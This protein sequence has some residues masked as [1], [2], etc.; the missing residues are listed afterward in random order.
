[1]SRL[2]EVLEKLSDEV[3]AISRWLV[4]RGR[5]MEAHFLDSL[6][7]SKISYSHSDILADYSPENLAS[8]RPLIDKSAGLLFR[9]FSGIC[10]EFEHQ[11]QGA[12]LALAQP[13]DIRIQYEDVTALYRTV[14]AVTSRYF[15]D[16]VAPGSC[17]LCLDQFCASRNP[18]EKIKPIL[19]NAI[20]L[21]PNITPPVNLWLGAASSFGV[22]DA[23]DLHGKTALC[24]AMNYGVR[25]VKKLIDALPPSTTR[26]MILHPSVSDKQ[27][28]IQTA[29]KGDHPG[30]VKLLLE[31]HERL[32]VPDTP[33]PLSVDLPLT[34]S[35]EP[36]GAAFGRD[37]GPQ[38]TLMTAILGENDYIISQ[39][40]SGGDRWLEST[41]TLLSS[42]VGEHPCF[43]NPD[44]GSVYLGPIHAAAWMSNYN[45]VRK[46]VSRK[47]KLH[48]SNSVWSLASAI[49]L[50]IG[51]TALISLF[52]EV[53]IQMLPEQVF[54]VTAA[55]RK[56]SAP[57]VVL[58][59]GPLYGSYIGI[60]EASAKVNNCPSPK[61]QARNSEICTLQWPGSLSLVESGGTPEYGPI[62]KLFMKRT[63]AEAE[64]SS[65]SSSL[66]S[67]YSV[68][69]L[70]FVGPTRDL[71]MRVGSNFGMEPLREETAENY[72]KE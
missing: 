71:Y 52:N 58:E 13:L 36:L 48:D 43:E 38:T 60:N 30:L 8:N 34:F 32:D 10:K 63:R 33:T 42:M 57:S 55:L 14:Q 53:K 3:Q 37:G 2:D 22:L 18:F 24:A 1:M 61:E 46:L 7:G 23:I 12:A 54:E 25:A 67:M 19:F 5:G 72:S 45:L 64:G 20:F 56:Y 59:D 69:G 11:P 39:L 47:G 29:V 26:R 6:L 51:N 40:I 27:T 35:I 17:S 66:N 16:F 28:L 50:G 68:G 70:P 31:L 44:L 49:I 4:S 21:N 62:R 9:W 41:T 65:R 15:Q